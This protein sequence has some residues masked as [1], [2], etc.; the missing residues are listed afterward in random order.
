LKY[1]QWLANISFNTV[2]NEQLN[3]NEKF[4]F[5][6]AWNE[7]AEGT[8]LEPDAHRGYS[9]LQN[10]YE[11]IKLFN[12]KNKKFILKQKFSKKNDFAIV[13]HIHYSD[14]WDEI[15]KYLKNIQETNF[16]LYI[17]LT[18]DKNEILEKI[19]KEFPEANI[20]IV[21][22]RGR[23]IRPFILTYKNIRSLGYKA[24][25]K[26]HSK[27]SMYRNDGNQIRAEI[28]D[29]L[30]GDK[31][32]L[33]NILDAFSDKKKNIGLIAPSKY[34]IEHNN[35]NMTYDF[36]IVRS[37][38]EYLEFDFEFSVFP[39]GSMFWFKPESLEG[40]EKIED[41][42]FEVEEG[43]ADGTLAHAIER[44]FVSLIK[45]NGFEYHSL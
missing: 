17:T 29:I 21:E 19:H 42:F 40:L 31:E 28:F 25:C 45:N 38:S 3:E 41:H 6:N 33:K 2:N 5:I 10:T 9:Y 35:K 43:L 8:H 14:V 20:S 24:I 15:V 32:K 27:K 23:D 4:I 7:W 30:I 13:L 16:D 34:L 11:I 36:D 37:I 26:I 44:I 1:K 22:N 12:N 18:N 39:A